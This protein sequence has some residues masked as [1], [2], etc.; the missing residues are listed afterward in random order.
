MILAR[1]A[2]GAKGF[3][4]QAALAPPCGMLETVACANAQDGS[5]GAQ[6]LRTDPQV[7]SATPEP[8]SEHIQTT[9]G[10]DFDYIAEHPSSPTAWT[11]PSSSSTA[12]RA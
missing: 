9:G 2:S 12:M 4:G 5:R 11:K 7:V 1:W 8:L 6:D 10:A 3:P